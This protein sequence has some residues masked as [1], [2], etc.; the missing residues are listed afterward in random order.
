MTTNHLWNIML[1]RH[2]LIVIYNKRKIA[3]ALLTAFL[4]LT[5][6]AS[7]RTF[8]AQTG[9]LEYDDVIIDFAKLDRNQLRY[10]ADFY[11]KKFETVQDKN[12]KEKNMHTAMGKYYLL[13]IMPPLDIIPFVQLARLYDADN[14]SRLAKEYFYKAAN[15][16]VNNPFA[17]YYFGEYYYKRCDYKRA[18]NYYTVAYN[19]GYN[20]VYDLNLRLGTIYEKFADLVNAKRF[21]EASYSLN[22]QNTELQ[23]KI[24]SLNELNYDKSEYYH[25]IRE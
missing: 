25:F 7:T 18:L 19:N 8:A 21:Y 2:H 5:V 4:L 20:N 17:N 22:P 15:I 1:T 6:C 14:K 12:E 11:F 13:T 23:E 10:E 16:E 3:S 9:Y 24:H